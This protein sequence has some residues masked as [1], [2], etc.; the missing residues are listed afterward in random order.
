MAERLNSITEEGTE[1]ADTCDFD[2]NAIPGLQEAYQNAIQQIA[3]DIT[4]NGGGDKRTVSV[5]VEY[6][7]DDE[8]VKTT[9]KVKLS[10][11]NPETIELPAVWS[12]RENGTLRLE[13]IRQTS[14]L[15]QN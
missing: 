12:I 6:K 9:A 1:M 7:P 13:T 8:G 15:D 14:I 3:D 5:V 2:L 4:E 11:P 10:L